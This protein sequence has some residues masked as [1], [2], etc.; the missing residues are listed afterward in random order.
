VPRLY[1]A[2]ASP[3]RSCSRSPWI[4]VGGTDCAERGESGAGVGT[5]MGTSDGRGGMALGFGGGSGSGS[6]ARDV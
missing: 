2:F 5:R 6:E 1:N 3:I 4:P